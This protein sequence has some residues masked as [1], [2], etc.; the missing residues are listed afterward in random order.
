M[1][2]VAPSPAALTTCREEFTRMS[3][4]AKMPGAS[5][6]IQSLT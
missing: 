4:A 2:A 1:A 5:V 6:Y 3:P